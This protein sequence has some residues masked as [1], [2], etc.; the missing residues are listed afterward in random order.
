[1]PSAPPSKPASRLGAKIRLLRRQEGLNQVQLAEARTRWV[2]WERYS[3]RQD[4]RMKLGGFVGEVVYEGNLAPF[5]P[6][7]VLG[8]MLHVGIEPLPCRG[9]D[10]P[11]GLEDAVEDKLRV[12]SQIMQFLHD[13]VDVREQSQ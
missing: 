9:L 13:V 1:M 8:E 11:A 7:L 6:Y 10:G 3:S 2:D 4:T 5:L 12:L